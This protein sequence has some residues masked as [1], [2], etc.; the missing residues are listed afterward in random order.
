MGNKKS[1]KKFIA[2]LINPGILTLDEALGLKS[3]R[4]E[5]RDVFS[6]NDPDG[7][8]TNAVLNRIGSRFSG[9]H[10]IETLTHG[11][12]LV[13]E[14]NALMGEVLNGGF[15]Q[16]LWNSSGDFA[17]KTRSML[18]EI[19]APST[20]ALLDR[21]AGAFPDGRIPEERE[22]RCRLIEDLENGN[23]EVDLFADE[24]RVFYQSEENLNRLLVEYIVN[25]R[26]E[27]V[28]PT[29]E[30][31]R[32]YKTLQGIR[33]RFGVTDD[34]TALEDA[35]RAL[36]VM[37]TWAETGRA[38][39]QQER[40]VIVKSLLDAGR[41]AEAVKTYRSTFNCSL[42]EAKTAVNGMKQSP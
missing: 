27:F 22:D 31:V 5:R 36:R 42:S 26:E 8:V 9:P 33:E 17:E 30:I 14:L 39:F 1:L 18:R 6:N 20:A 21:V 15:H 25:H 35:E 3:V 32:Q 38:E 16:Y 19:G 12:R 28:E 37:E 2:D 13:L 7:S 29:D 4:P 11:E 23:P 41:T 10:N 40:L 24:D 34:P